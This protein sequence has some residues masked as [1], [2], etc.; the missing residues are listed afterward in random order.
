MSRQEW[1]YIWF[2]LKDILKREKRWFA[3]MLLFGAAEG[4]LP[5]IGILGM[6][7]LLGAAYEGA[8]RL[9]TY[10]LVI[11]LGILVCRLIMDRAAAGFWQKLDYTKDLEAKGMNEK[12]LSMDYEYLEDVRVQELRSRAFPN[13]F[14]GFRGGLYGT[15]ARCWK[16]RFLL[17]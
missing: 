1:G 4:I 11:L 17:F 2:L 9:F 15:C 7:K 16:R 13:P 14:S 3:S 10:A 8:E 5:Y 6:G 12:S